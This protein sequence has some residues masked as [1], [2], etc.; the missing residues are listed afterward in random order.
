MSGFRGWVFPA[1][2][3]NTIPAS[4]KQVRQGDVLLEPVGVA[5]KNLKPVKSGT[6][7]VIAF[8]EVTGHAHRLELLDAP[9]AERDGVEI[10]QKDWIKELQDEANNRYFEVTRAATVWHEDHGYVT[11]APGMYRYVPQV[12]GSPEGE[13]QVLD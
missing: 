8:G 4:P 2:L 1:A 12:E 9:E 7:V 11:L 6:M 3:R 10:P 13:R 5:P